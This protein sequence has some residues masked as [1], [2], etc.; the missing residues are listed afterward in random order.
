MVE[1]RLFRILYLLL[2]KGSTT[3]PELARLFEVSVRTIYRDIERLSMAGIPLYSVSG[4]AGGIFLMKDFVLDRT[5]VSEDEKLELLSALQGIQAL[6]DNR[7]DI[8][9]EKLES[10]FQVSTSPWIEVDLTDW[11]KREGQKELFDN[12]K[13]AILEKRRLVITYLSGSGQKTVRTVEPFK[14]V[15]KKRDWYLHAYCCL[16]E[17]WRFFKLSRIRNYHLTNETVKQKNVMDSVEGSE[18]VANQI[19]VFLKFSPK[20]AFRVY[21]DF[22]EDEIRLGEDGYYYVK[23]VLPE[24]ESLYSYLLSYLDGVEILE[25]SRLKKEFLSKLEKIQKLYKP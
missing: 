2:E 23:T 21:E 19:E 12:I 14:L 11:R 9:L 7:Q 24:H 4:K 17:D 16:K 22:S 8:L 6:T 10:I 3:A 25:P 15:F 1:S 18:Q 13:Q 20:L 5:L